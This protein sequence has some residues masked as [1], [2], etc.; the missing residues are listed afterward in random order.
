VYHRVFRLYLSGKLSPK[1]LLDDVYDEDMRDVSLHR[2]NVILWGGEVLYRTDFRDICTIL[3]EEK[4]SQNILRTYG[5]PLLKKEILEFVSQKFNVVRLVV[6]TFQKDALQWLTGLSYTP[7]H[8]VRIIGEIQKSSLHLE[9]EIPLTRPTMDHLLESISFLGQMG[10]SR[11]IL[12][13]IEPQGI[14]KDCYTMLAPR[15]GLL[16]TIFMEAQI[17]AQSCHMN[18]Y[19]EDIPMCV[20][21][22]VGLDTITVLNPQRRRQHVFS[23]G[24]YFGSGIEQPT[25]KKCLEQH[26]SGIDVGYVESFGISELLPEHQNTLPEVSY[27]FTKKQSSKDIKRDLVWLSRHTPEKIHIWGDW[28]HP[29]SYGILRDIQRLSIPNISLWGDL[30]GL[31]HIQ[32]REW[33]RLRKITSVHAQ[34][35]GSTEEEHDSIRGKGHFQLQLGIMKKFPKAEYFFAVVHEEQQCNDFILRWEDGTLTYPLK[36][37]R[38]KYHMDTAFSP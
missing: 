23:E 37:V 13:M 19:F 28:E 17:I 6:P 12:R 5:I 27:I 4:T 8:I 36:I 32:D 22:S 1:S 29:Q 20:V 25:P 18:I 38:N 24:V 7:K 3:E 26:C 33:F 34:I 9:V 2:K 10:V 11:V 30:G 21:S 14:A 31:H 15:L 16:S 35:F